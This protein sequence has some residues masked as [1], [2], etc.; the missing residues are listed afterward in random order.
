MKYKS[1]EEMPV[2]QEAHRL[3]ILIYR[4]SDGFPKEETYNLVSQMRRAA[5]SVEANIA[6]AFG[7]HHL[8][9]K[10]NF[11]YNSRGS[12]EELHSHSITARDLKMLSAEDFKIIVSI[13]D[14]IKESINAII[15]TFGHIIDGKAKNTQS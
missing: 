2:W 11:Y 6:E 10:R 7:R 15:S 3:A 9:D 13:A 8:A 5:L 1:F 4:I 14:V 12:L